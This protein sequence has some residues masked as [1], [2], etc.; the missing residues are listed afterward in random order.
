MPKT[1]DSVTKHLIELEPEKWVELLELSGDEAEAVDS[2]LS[3]IAPQ[4]DKVI[5]VK[6]ERPYTLHIEFQSS[7]EPDMAE[8]F[9]VY[10]T[11][12]GYRTKLPVRTV[13]FL[14]RRKADGTVMN[15]PFQ[16]HYENGEPYHTFH[17][18]VVRL[19]EEPVERYLEGGLS[20]IPLA[21]LC[22]VKPKD[23]PAVLRR[24]KERI[25]AEGGD[26]GTLWTATYLLMGVRHKSSVVDRLLKGVRK[27]K[28]STTY[29]AIIEEGRVEGEARG[30][31]RGE[32]NLI[33]LIGGK[34]FGEPSAATLAQL[35]AIAIPAE[36]ERLAVRLL[37]VESWGE[38]LKGT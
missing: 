11:L 17:F 26:E 13:V 32:R 36:L 1:Y 20:T 10:N 21:P 38:L 12:I 19:W 9:M 14:L 28:E 29:Q 8:R 15:K 23:L 25:D 5:R 24:M 22:A 6:G 30:E 2:D 4:A 33:L 34:R 3:T 31:A 16:K 37:E 27:M 7:Y 18:R 35:E